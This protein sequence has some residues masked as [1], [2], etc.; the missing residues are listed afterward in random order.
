M[1]E[2][3]KLFL[4]LV[5]LAGL[6]LLL[7]ACAAVGG[8]LAGAVPDRLERIGPARVDLDPPQRWMLAAYLVARAPALDEPAGDIK[9][10]LELSVEQGQSAGEVVDALVA[11]GVVADGELLRNYMRYRGLDTGIEAGQYVISGALTPRQ[12]AERLQSA[13]VQQVVLTVLEGWRLEEI[14]Q[15]LPTESIAFGPRE[16][17]LVARRKMQGFSF[18]ADAPESASLE[19]FLFPDTYH[20]DPEMGAE[21]LVRQMLENF[22]RRVDGQMRAGFEAEGLNL[23]Q[24]VTLA[25]IIEREAVVDEERGLIASVFFNRLRAGMKLEADPTVQYALGQ[26]PDGSWWK[27]PLTAEDLALDSLYN[28]YMY[29]G[30]PPGPIAN[31]G[32]ESLRAVAFPEETDFLYFRTACDGSGRHLFARTFEEHLGNACP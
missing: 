9:A 19:G 32:L 10:T 4:R 12:I 22:D 5:F 27:S 2:T 17:L 16:F 6:L 11:A 15:A 28:T 8:L 1:R 7:C 18:L 30:L 21:D 23:Y 31:P 20:L 29:P 25:S 3:I 13:A 26:Q 14:A 24:A